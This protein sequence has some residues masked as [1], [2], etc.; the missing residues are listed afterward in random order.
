MM[1]PKV[2]VGLMALM[3]PATFLTRA[4]LLPDL[5]NKVFL[6]NVF[7]TSSGGPI[8]CVPFDCEGVLHPPLNPPGLEFF[9]TSGPG[10]VSGSYEL[11]ANSSRDQVKGTVTLS[12]G[13]LTSTTVSLGFTASTSFD[14]EVSLLSPLAPPPVPVTD[15]PVLVNA[16]GNVACAS[17]RPGAAFAKASF[18]I[19]TN[20]DTPLIASCPSG[21]PSFNADTTAA[22]PENTPELV[23]IFVQGGVGDTAGLLSSVTD[24]FNAIVDPTFE[25][26]PSFPYASYFKLEYSPGFSQQAV[27]EPDYFLVLGGLL[28]VLAVCLWKRPLKQYPPRA[29]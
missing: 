17:D 16:T 15:I 23:V 27:P 10:P 24:S 19:A 4:D 6:T 26:D 20:P 25:I 13:L 7:S 14:V 18:D 29:C 8:Q 12:S 21:D 1:I 2:C 3:G 11:V 28:S 22:F 9:V 5:V